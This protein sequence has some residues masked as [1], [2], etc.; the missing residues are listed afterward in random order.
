MAHLNR[1]QKI[2]ASA[3]ALVL[4]GSGSAAFAYWSTSGTGTGAGSTTAGVADQLL[5]TG[6]V[7][8]AL[9]PGQAAQNFTV[10]V[11]NTADQSSYVTGLKASVTTDK[12]PDCDGSNFSINGSA[13]AALPVALTWT[14]QDLAKTAQ[15]TSI[16]TIQFVDKPTNQDLCKGAVVTLHYT[17]N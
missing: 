5:I 11:K 7:A 14:A 13:S 3:T 12:G 17:A 16:N 1:R 6:D 4:I 2:A 8:N 15:D 10:T 9:F